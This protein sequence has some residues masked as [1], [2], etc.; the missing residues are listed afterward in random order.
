MKK[1]LLKRMAAA[2]SSLAVLISIFPVGQLPISYAEDTT[3]VSITSSDELSDTTPV[4]I[5]TD[6]Q[7]TE[8]ASEETVESATETTTQTTAITSETMTSEM[9]DHQSF[10]TVSFAAEP[11]FIVLV[12]DETGE[13]QPVT[14]VIAKA[15]SDVLFKVEGTPFRTV[16]IGES[17]VSLKDD[18]YTI[19]DLQSSVTVDIANGNYIN[20]IKVKYPNKVTNDHV[21]LEMRRP[22]AAKWVYYAKIPYSDGLKVT[23]EDVVNAVNNSTD[24]KIAGK[25][26]YN[27]KEPLRLYENGFYYFVFENE[28]GTYRNGVYTCT[29]RQIDKTAPEVSVDLVSYVYEKNGENIENT[30]FQV[31]FTVSDT[32]ECDD[33]IAELCG[34]SEPLDFSLV[35]DLSIKNPALSG[36]EMTAVEGTTDRF[37]ITADY[38]GEYTQDIYIIVKDKAGNQTSAEIKTANTTTDNVEL[39][40]S[41]DISSMADRC[42]VRVKAPSGWQLYYLTEG[43][44]T[45]FKES[46]SITDNNKDYSII[47]Y[48]DGNE[49]G[50][51]SVFSVDGLD[52]QGPE[53]SIEDEY[54][55]K[56]RCA[57]NT[58]IKIR[59]GEADSVLYTYRSS[60][61]VTDDSYFFQSYGFVSTKD[62]VID[63]DV[64]PEEN[65]VW[66]YYFY[67]ADKYGNKSDIIE[68]V[69]MIDSDAPVIE[70]MPVYVLDDDYGFIQVI[71]NTLSFDMFFDEYAYVAFSAID[72]GGSEIA[73]YHY[74]FGDEW[75]ETELVDAVEGYESFSQFIKIP[76]DADGALSIKVTDGAGNETTY[77]FSNGLIGTNILINSQT[78]SVPELF[79][80]HSD[81]SR[82]FD[83]KWTNNDVTVSLTGGDIEYEDGKS[84]NPQKYQY[85]IDGVTWTDMP[86]SD[87]NV[88]DSVGG[89]VMDNSLTITHETDCEYLYRAVGYNGKV[90]DTGSFTVRIDETAPQN[91]EYEINGR[92]GIL[93]DGKESGWY[94]EIFSDELIRIE[95]PEED[96]GSPLKVWYIFSKDGS[97][98][99]P[100]EFTGNNYPQYTGDG[101][102]TFLM[103]TEDEAGN[104]SKETVY[105]E[106]KVD[107]SAPECMELAI[108]DDD[109]RIS[110]LPEADENGVI[111]SMK[112]Y[113]SHEINI[114]A[115]FSFDV[116]GKY[117][118][119]YAF[120]NSASLD[121]ISSLEWR[122]YD[123]SKGITAKPNMRF[124][125]Y[126]K[127][128]DNAGNE[129]IVNSDGII[130]DAEKPAGMDE[131]PGI[132]IIPDSYHYGEFYNGDLNVRIYAEDPSVTDYVPY[133]VGTGV[134]SGLKLVEYSVYSNGTET[135]SGK[136]DIDEGDESAD[137]SFTINSSLNNTND[138]IVEVRAVDMAGNECVTRTANGRIK[139]DTTAPEIVVS[140]NGDSPSAVIGG[141]AYFNSTR[142][143]SIYITE[144]NF[145]SGGV[146]CRITNTD[147][148]SPSINGWSVSGN[149]DS[150]VYTGSVTY[151]GDGDYTFDI[152][153][154]DMAGNRCTNISYGSSSAPRE[155]TIDRTNPTIS[156]DYEDM[157][158]A[159]KGGYFNASRK[160]YITINE[161][162]FS[163]ENV[164]I[165]ASAER[166]GTLIKVPADSIEWTSQG[167]IR[168]AVVDYA[169]DGDY[170]FDIVCSDMAKNESGEAD[171]GDSPY[172][173]RFTIDT[174]IKAPIVLI[175]DTRCDGKAY[176][177]EAV[178]SMSFED[179]NYA[180]HSVVLTQVAM[181]ETKDVTDELIGRLNVTDGKCS[182][183]LKNIPDDDRS[184]D[185]IYNLTILLTDMAHNTSKTS[186]TFSVNRYGSVYVFDDYLSSLTAGGGAY[187]QEIEEDIVITEYNANRLKSGSLSI[188]VTRD[189]R[190]ADIISASVDPVI[191]ENAQ[192]GDSGW[193]QYKYVLSKETFSADGVY[194]IVV[195]SEDEAGNTPENTYYEDQ[196]ILFHVDSTAPELSR[197][198]GLE[199]NIINK[200]E[201]NVIYSVFDAMGLSRLIVYVDGVQ[202]QNI[203]DFS[204]DANSFTGEFVISES[205]DAQSVRIVVVDLAGNVT[206]TDSGSFITPYRFERFVTVST[207]ILV[208]AYANKLFF[209]GSVCAGGVIIALVCL[210]VFRRK[211]K[212][213]HDDAK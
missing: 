17:F 145:S 137:G 127:A 15:G 209:W 134:Y 173:T 121:A 174:V 188:I 48:K 71:A 100:V 38:K 169:S 42:Q 179:I 97:Q 139:I 101:I 156:V 90:S 120:S 149:G 14:S 164:V 83:G 176:S 205:K 170:T 148:S 4:E 81:N 157:D 3:E 133:D 158:T 11:G 78:P 184:Y 54:N 28:E 85:S 10:Y 105:T 144:R 49:I 154:T 102:Y 175:N 2:A 108:A 204:D 16:K 212:K 150:T 12:A 189:G 30:K 86:E 89:A 168:K 91:A 18:I 115:E 46:F 25:Y 13:Y 142:S 199:K 123:I 75:T 107:T 31:F 141:T 126:M 45:R 29:V 210:I 68:Y 161:H 98:D 182:V 113:Y 66:Y 76:A 64:L 110:I 155:F 140:Y 22:Y 37:K 162:N 56:W 111:S 1:G 125:L 99:E 106:I 143:A 27:I 35:N 131:V 23:M 186:V 177:D 57:G 36:A 192:A 6:V 197:I 190:P 47:A 51:T 122:E 67:A 7:V 159:D 196:S 153:F 60:E 187:V 211:K 194:K 130:I 119:M 129:T 69:Y 118:L 198:T 80:T 34:L 193:Y 128:V 40:A 74:T 88:M 26:E 70:A 52:K 62:T 72:T 203:T 147:G 5:P 109:N 43:N 87:G 167:D 202:V 44:K 151:S 163:P 124:Y 136:L 152:S 208:R 213:L 195:S 84:L 41:Y 65:A 200:K 185:G 206:D 135:Q 39:K 9:K 58:S 114:E 132:S 160:A 8:P 20:P 178:I 79:M 201:Q 166:D 112:Y 73:S 32:D 77:N 104:I 21:V 103:W 24:P 82:Y 117:Q 171:Y 94:T 53:L 181:G 63:V 165:T 59:V 19:S 95:M 92:A 61:P 207:N 96:G 191:D 146:S 138:V 180:S 116:S 183:T 55:G 50:R 93:P 33:H 172:P